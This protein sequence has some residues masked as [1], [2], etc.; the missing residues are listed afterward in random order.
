MKPRSRAGSVRL[1]SDDP[2]APLAI[3]HGFLDDPRDADTLAEGLE[4]LRALA[5]SEAVGPYVA[6]ELRPGR[7]VDAHG[8]AQ[9]T[10]RGFFHPVGTCALGSV[11]DERGA[12]FGLENVYVG[13]ASIM[14][15]IPRANTNLSTA[16]IAERIAELFP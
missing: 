1:R 13:D 5:R 7:E 2:R 9:A 15:S 16:A 10:A 12:V 8:H 6:E 14:P 4:A 3:E 11:V